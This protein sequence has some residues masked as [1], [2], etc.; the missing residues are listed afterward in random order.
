MAKYIIELEDDPF[1]SID[2]PDSLYRAKGFKSL[3][4]DKNG[5]EKLTPYKEPD[6]WY[7]GEFSEG[8]IVR[9]VEYGDVGI[10]FSV[11]GKQRGYRIFWRDVYTTLEPPESMRNMKKIGTTDDVEKT[12]HD[13]TTTS[14]SS[15]ISC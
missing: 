4:F 14:L 13:W 12:I 9:D 2:S 6:E 1:V 5:I 7:N 8:D 15:Y 11:S 10:I 3:V